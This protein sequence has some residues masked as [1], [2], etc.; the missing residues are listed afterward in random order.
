MPQVL[1]DHSSSLRPVRLGPAECL[2]ERQADGTIF[3]RSPQRLPTYPKALTERLV[4]W[5]NVAPSRLFLAD[6]GPDGA[7][8]MLTYADTLAKVRNIGAALLRRGLSAERPLVILSGNDLEHQ[9]LGLAAMHVG[10]P[11][12][13]ISPAYSLISTDFGKL[14]YIVNLL[15]PGLV[16]AS[17]GT[18]FA[19]AIREVVASDVELVFTRGAVA[20]RPA[21]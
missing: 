5:A 4:H 14:R 21:T 2:L 1:R 12:A 11:Y 8:R 16:F 13:P 9:L 7:W 19:R 17:D 15:T 20:D 18:L 3:I 10:I 6:R